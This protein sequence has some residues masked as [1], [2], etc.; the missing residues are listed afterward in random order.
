VARVL[1]AELVTERL[2]LRQ[3]QEGDVAPMAA[4]NTDPEVTRLL[5]RRV[6]AAAV[7]GF[8]AAARQHW[9]AHGFGIYAVEPRVGDLAGRLVGFVGFA[10]ADFIPELS[11][12]PEL[13]WRLAR[14]AWGRGFAYEA[15]CAVHDVARGQSALTGFVSVIHP[16][17]VR[18]Q[19]LARRLG[20]TVERQVHNPVLGRDVDVWSLR[21]P[22]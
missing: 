3:W 6:D 12:R 10:P 13:G 9:D 5:N 15:A 20:L 11:G 18:S 19:R 22:G 8:V 17:N 16:D 4:I 1:P 7:S 14:A 21:E 2:C